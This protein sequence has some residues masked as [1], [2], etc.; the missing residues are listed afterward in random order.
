MKKTYCNLAAAFAV[1]FAA[2]S[3]F[4]ADDGDIYEFKPV[5]DVVASGDALGAAETVEFKMRLLSPN[6]AEA[7]ESK[8]IQWQVYY[9]PDPF[10][11]QPG[12]VVN[13][14]AAWAVNPPKIGIVVSGQT[15]GAALG[16][17]SPLGNRRFTEFD[18]TYTT[19]YGDFALPI[20]LAT[21]DKGTAVGDGQAGA[22]NPSTDGQYYFLNSDTWGIGYLP[23]GASETYENIVWLKP[24]RRQ[25]VSV[26]APDGVR[27]GSWDLAYGFDPAAAG[28]AYFVKTL[29]FDSQTATDS[30]G[31]YWRIVNE[32]RTTC[33]PDVPA[34]K[35][36]NVPQDPQN[37][38]VYVWSENDDVVTV[39]FSDS[40][41]ELAAAGVTKETF[42]DRTG[43]SRDFWVKKIKLD[44]VTVEYPFAIRG[45]AGASGTATTLV[46]SAKLGYRFDGAGD[47]LEDFLVADVKCGDPLLPTVT[48]KVNGG[49]SA[50][51]DAV[52]QSGVA[53]RVATL[54]VEVS[55][56]YTG[57]L[58]VDIAPKLAVD[59]IAGGDAFDYFGISEK[60]E[61]LSYLDKVS[62]VT[63]TA[64]D[65]SVAS[66]TYSKTLY[67]YSWGADANTYAVN[68]SVGFYP[69]IADT[70][71]AAFYSGGME[72][73]YLQVKPIKPV[74]VE[75]VA[76]QLI[77]VNASV[78]YP[79]TVKVS[80]TYNDMKSDTGYELFIKRDIGDL[81]FTSLGFFK[82]DA[83][84]VLYSVPTTEDPEPHQPLVTWENTATETAVLYVK[85]PESKE[86]SEERQIKLYVKPARQIAVEA[87]DG[88]DGNQYVEGEDVT[89]SVKLENG[90]ND[91][92][93]TIYAF[94]VPQSEE[95]LN[96]V[97]A[98]WVAK[99]GGYGREIPKS[100]STVNGIFTLVDGTYETAQ[101]ATYDFKIELR[102]K[103]A[104]SDPGGKVVAG[105]ESKTL[106]VYSKNVIPTA[107]FVELNDGIDTVDTDGAQF[108][109]IIAKDVPTKFQMYV[110]EPGTYDKTTDVVGKKFKTRWIV[111]EQ[112][113][114][115]VSTIVEGN[116]DTIPFE[117]TFTKAGIATIEVDFMDKDM[118]DK[119]NRW[120]N[121][122]ENKKFT[123]K[124][125][126]VSNPLITITTYT[127]LNGFEEAECTDFSG[128]ASI[129]V[130]VSMNPL[131]E[132]LRV[133]L[134]IVPPSYSA[135]DN[136][137]M[138]KLQEDANCT[139][140]GVDGDGNDTYEVTL[141]GILAQTI[142]VKTLDGTPLSGKTPGFMIKSKVLNDTIY[143]NGSGKKSSEYYIGVDR[144]LLV[145]NSDPKAEVTDFY[146][147]PGSTNHVAIGT[148][149]PITWNFTD[150]D[151][152]F[153]KG[154]TVT[155]KQTGGGHTETVY[156]SA[157]ASGSWAPTFTASGLQIVTMTI[158]DKDN[159]R[160]RDPELIWYYEV[161]VS[162]KLNIT[163]NGPAD[164]GGGANSVRYSKAKG[165][166]RGHVY[167]GDPASVVEFTSTYNCGISKT[168][169]IWGF[170]Y[171]VASP[172]DNGTLDG[173]KDFGVTPAGART[174]TEPFY[175]Y[176]SY[177]DKGGQPVDSF[178]YAWLQYTVGEGNASSLTDSLLGGTINP[179]TVSDG[180]TTGSRKL[181]ALPTELL[182]D[183]TYADVMIEA[184]FSREYRSSD[185]MGDMN[186]DGIPDSYILDYG[187]GIYDT[188]GRTVTGDDLLNVAD[189][190]DDEDMLPATASATIASPSS[191]NAWSVAT[192]PFSAIYE[193]RGY[194]DGLNIPG[195][196]EMDM[197]DNE[198]RAFKRYIVSIA[199]CGDPDVTAA[200]EAFTSATNTTSDAYTNETAKLKAVFDKRVVNGKPVW[201][202]EN[203]TDPTKADTD[204]DEIDDGYEYYFWYCAHV[205]GATGER[206]GFWAG[207]VSKPT[208]ISSEEVERLFD[209]NVKRDWNTGGQFATDTDGDGL[210]DMVEIT[211]TFTNPIHW[212][213]DG[214]GMPD[215]LEVM[216]GLDPL[217]NDAS[218]NPD[219][220]FMAYTVVSDQLVV[221]VE[222][223]DGKMEI[224]GLDN[225]HSKSKNGETY[226]KYA[227]VP[228][229]DAASYGH[230][231]YVLVLKNDSGKDVPQFAFLTEKDDEAEAA[232]ELAKYADNDQVLVDMPVRKLYST[233]ET[234]P[235]GGDKVNRYWFGASTTLKAGKQ[236]T[237]ILAD[238]AIKTINYWATAAAL[239]AE[240]LE[241]RYA[242]LVDG[243]HDTDDKPNG[244]DPAAVPGLFSIYRLGDAENGAY[245]V[246]MS[247]RLDTDYK[248]KSQVTGTLTYYKGSPTETADLSGADLQIVRIETAAKVARYHAQIFA[249]NG[250]DPRTGWHSCNDGYC[251]ERWCKTHSLNTKYAEE[252]GIAGLAVNTS[253]FTALNEYRLMHY[254]YVNGLASSGT[255]LS[256]AVSQAKSL[257]DIWSVRTTNPQVTKN[258]AGDVTSHGADTDGDGAPDGWE[259]YVLKNPNPTPNGTD[260]TDDEWD[261]VHEDGA[262]SVKGDGD[263]LELPAEFA[264]TDSLLAYIDCPTIGGRY[265][266]TEEGT[267]VGWI[268]LNKFFPTNPYSSDTDGDGLSDAEEMAVGMD[269]ND[270]SGTQYGNSDPRVKP[271]SFIYG[272]NKD[273]NTD[274]NNWGYAN[275]DGSTCI[276]GGGLNPCTVD[277]DGDRLP[278]G[279]EY[280]FAGIY[281]A[282]AVN[283][284][285]AKEDGGYIDFGMDGTD[286]Y[287]ARTYKRGSLYPEDV[288]PRTG[289]LRN[290]DFDIDGLQNYQEYLTQTLRHFRYDV[291][292]IGTTKESGASAPLIE[293]VMN[294][295]PLY[296][297][298][299]EGPIDYVFGPSAT[300]DAKPAND[301]TRRGFF[302]AP[303]HDWDFAALRVG[304]ARF[305]R[306][307]LTPG[308]TWGISKKPDIWKPNGYV[309]AH[310]Y[311]TTDPRMRDS[312]LD[313]MDDFYELFHGLNPLLGQRSAIGGA[314][315]DLVALAY[316]GLM[317][318]PDVEGVL[319]LDCFNNWFSMPAASSL[320]PFMSLPMDFAKYPWL[321]GMP[322]AD[323]D[324]DGLRNDQEMIQVN[325]ANPQPSNTDPTP[326][327]MTDP[328]FP[329]SFTAQYY[330]QGMLA[331]MWPLS[332]NAS[333]GA[334][335]IE[336]NGYMF[337]F[338]M[339]EGY[340]TDNDGVPDGQEI[341]KTARSA[342]DPQLFTDPMVRQAL[343]FPG[344]V[345]DVS[346]LAI[347]FEPA[348]PANT[349][350]RRTTSA[351]DIFR[352]F[353]V[354]CWI[355]P[356]SAS[357]GVG[358]KCTVLER[359]CAYPQSNYQTSAEEAGDDELHYVRATFRI[360]IE[361]GYLYGL[362][363]NSD[364]QESEAYLGVSSA[365]VVSDVALAADTW[366]HVA[367]TYD[368]AE[369]AIIVK[370]RDEAD[371]KGRRKALETSIIPANGV[372]EILQQPNKAFPYYAYEAY[373]T[374]FLLGASADEVG[375]NIHSVDPKATA[376]NYSRHYVGYIGE[377][378][379]WD[380]VRTID[381]IAAAHDRKLSYDEIVQI[382]NDVY[383]SWYQGGTRSSTGGTE[384]LPAELVQQYTFDGL[385]GA[386]EPDYVA[387]VPSAFDYNVKGPA[388][389][390]LSAAN[391]IDVEVA[392]G[393]LSGLD[394]SLRPSVYND[395]AYVPWIK[396]M[397]A[398]L[399]MMDGSVAD[400]I[401]W[402]EN[403][404]GDHPPVEAEV[405][406]YVFPNTANP[407]AFAINTRDLTSRHM[408]YTVLNGGTQDEDAVSTN[409]T[410]SSSIYSSL[411]D[412]YRFDLRCRMSGT[413]DLVPLGGVYAKRCVDYWDGQGAMDADLV[414]S[415]GMGAADAKGNGLPDW[416]EEYCRDNYFSGMGYDPGMAMTLDT[417]VNYGGIEIKASEAYLRDLAKGMLPTASKDDDFKD[418]TD[419]DYDGMPDWWEKMYGIDT[420]SVEDSKADNDNDGLNNLTE[421]ILSE[422]FVLND[423]DGNRKV[424]SPIDVRSGGTI[425]TDYFFRVGDLY[426]GEIFADH[427]W[428]EDWWE[429]GYNADYVSMLEYDAASDKD[430]DGWSAWAESRYSQQVSPIVANNLFHYNVTDG[431]VPDYPIPTLQLKIRYNGSRESTVRNSSIGVKVGRSLDPSKSFDAEYYVRG[432]GHGSGSVA[433]TTAGSTASSN[434]YT[435]VIGKWSDRHVYGTL[436]PGFINSSS[437]ELQS[438]YDPSAVIYSWVVRVA[439]AQISSSGIGL[440]GEVRELYQ[441]GTKAEYNQAMR[442]YGSDNVTL[443]SMSDGYGK[444]N[445]LEIRTDL[446]SEMATLRF[447][448]G[449]EVGTVNLK[450]GE[451]DLDLGV[452]K[453]GIVQNATNENQLAAL[454][455]QT[456]RFVYSANEST[457][458]PRDLYLGEANNGYIHEGKNSVMVW[459]DLDDDGEF[460]VGEPFGFAC[461]VDIGW[462]RRSIEV[463]IFDRS[464]VTPRVN[465]LASTMNAAVS[466]LTTTPSDR[467]ETI[468]D[469][470]ETISNR[471]VAV[472]DSPQARRMAMEQMEWINVNKYAP[473]E[474]SVG[475][476]ELTRVR[477]V[478][479]L[480]DGTPV[481][482]IGI[483]AEVVFDKMVNLA[484]HPTLTEADLLA[485]G[486]FDID[487]NW[488]AAEL[489]SDEVRLS[490]IESASVAYL[491]VI[492]D[493]PVMWRGSTDS[494][495]VLQV[496]NQVI[497][498]RF[499]VSQ[500]RAA[501]YSPGSAQSVVYDGRPTFSWT[502]PGSS[503]ELSYTAF[504]IQILPESGNGV[505][506]DSG[507]QPMPSRDANGR[508]VWK[509]PAYVGN[510][511]ESSVNYRWRVTGLN[512][513]FRTPLWSE[514]GV[515][516]MEPNTIGADCGRIDVCVKYFGPTAE[517]LNNGRVVVEAFESPDF[518]G[519]PAAR[520]V[521]ADK[522]AVAAVETAHAK[523]VTLLGLRKGTYYVRAYIDS[524]AY[525]ASNVRDSW[526]SW[527]YL[528]D[529]SGAKSDIF[530]P[531]ALEIDDAMGKGDLAVVYIE[532][533][534]TNGNRLPDAWE[535]AIN[536]GRLSNGTS[537]IDKTLDCG[538][539]VKDS[540]ADSISAKQDVSDTNYVGMVAHFLGTLRSRG[541]A[542]LALGVAPSAINVNA[543]GQIVVENEVKSVAIESISFE[544]GK[545]SIAVV[546]NVG[547]AVDAVASDLYDITTEPTKKVVC[548]V[549]RRNS[550]AAEDDWSLVTA[551]EVVVGVG[552]TEIAVPDASEASGFFKVVVRK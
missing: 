179:E 174:T 116:P 186:Q 304:G 299:M 369:F 470:Y 504:Q 150:V 390:S 385:H 388:E 348:H 144:S 301:A 392:V 210:P 306:F 55:D 216:R 22:F 158:T 29:G 382:R 237:S 516:R 133:Q 23:D 353:T 45:V 122:V 307:V 101:G 535:M 79:L 314:G 123:F 467:G 524:N 323:P 246:K 77:S 499:D 161:E 9:K 411:L 13:Y 85:S 309:A 222:K 58:V 347:S 42:K 204:G 178:L 201:T 81:S 479:W 378:R 311:A 345:G 62:K 508:Y 502:I 520:A 360:G 542:A 528:T 427:D 212:D 203:P 401:Y 177:F 278:D 96:A 140:T 317:F 478:R 189:Y 86:K 163:P 305:A 482:K 358:S 113:K 134:T 175:T 257:T 64:A 149:D 138:F 251:G 244:L 459:A 245:S 522:A 200:I 155:I 14:A 342:S 262:W 33:K 120:G 418:V 487:W 147:M 72:E 84:G 98:T 126:I 477:V 136:P 473:A 518:T 420:G 214:D 130:N 402:G 384:V 207:D 94:L 142:Y 48:V 331:A 383:D 37:L 221:E 532:D 233:S 457:G 452:F 529:R 461:D 298:T 102:T 148:A 379:V 118:A 375:M 19:R 447:D 497:E 288:D 100:G 463:E 359:V 302:G 297:M 209:P 408:R 527:G 169:D 90:N 164:G 217:K 202:P 490:D 92:G 441:R 160:V 279:W 243:V 329:Y 271:T 398:H 465:L 501:V 405:S 232:A 545:L 56:P 415:D 354:E 54:T 284:A 108:S 1:A 335:D 135:A 511:L 536:G 259:L 66:T 83:E 78:A 206:Y 256:D 449:M 544:G 248:A 265:S 193:I 50:T 31:T 538:L 439:R 53:T 320:V 255:D 462:R 370:A 419:F 543:S 468:D 242:A 485:D 57:D 493:G 95:A 534:D 91:T 139:Y 17:P 159:G 277:T 225:V 172:V 267:L 49:A 183:G 205:M 416:W 423:A 303:P 20:K 44:G 503:E 458:L 24:Y 451:Y 474:T 340:D 350:T 282:S 460:T 391:G 107:E 363:D 394:A 346:S 403:L 341:T 40:A 80:D 241:P 10:L 109:T 137:G 36:D 366:Y 11:T 70:A 270:Y 261:L 498:R 180:V 326:M 93:D 32:K 168:W 409:T 5:T 475:D 521:V 376:A 230:I 228:W 198:R 364:A 327:W 373:D 453:N 285:T 226:Y 440:V 396:N 276:R 514:V 481:Y 6:F 264:G 533:A 296:Q 154:I 238:G 552:E 410:T 496:A 328:T 223:D 525:G 71:A 157:D 325:T 454:E 247:C 197:S 21:D 374:A 181:I 211:G 486:A 330:Q 106:T 67:V 438:A 199:D 184:I 443:L 28:G 170:G 82:P 431:L 407:Y 8:R 220:D 219:G 166:G 310:S 191:S 456:Y 491:V 404:A 119:N 151:P 352:Q 483:P 531:L 484:E 386:T 18:C 399:P 444:L 406:K 111:K 290:F 156:N 7:L 103:K 466:Y 273:R 513:K 400:S 387:T 429:E 436:T 141:D 316:S 355:R 131:D 425:D 146:P 167:A 74:I 414:T 27:N 546:G 389:E 315:A 38:Y 371:R 551:K 99:D 372:T 3:A 336:G 492:G 430:G 539:A 510:E 448:N 280:Q 365:K 368:G 494:E 435:H 60:A 413:S 25:T 260:A 195:V 506:W 357:I 476:G 312:D 182:D 188:V 295:T 208:V 52:P 361:D 16:L 540:L 293:G 517:V 442:A 362:I 268:W 12:A 192:I 252:A 213:S 112:G 128:E 537:D 412:L 46:M 263:G 63:F 165:I 239:V 332:S 249:E 75:P 287:D 495:T 132:P 313:G 115:P 69:S 281:R 547:A 258:D 215:G 41:A 322:L 294:G 445:G 472:L 464:P 437:I 343:Y 549:Y 240:E 43:V 318:G 292:R 446:T 286:P 59:G 339:N 97:Q 426:I 275:D 480:V 125:E 523:Q 308:T 224:W 231:A 274:D 236:F 39:K 129:D 68:K 89:V 337:S 110:N 272:V 334:A 76:D 469:Y 356:E 417:L 433:G 319:P 500:A 515:F 171:K 422:R 432:S 30:S 127:S 117:Y 550:L 380:G 283:A 266:V 35:I 450:T 519:D 507:V 344:K 253:G 73:A 51:V 234:P 152:D 15:R 526:E 333:S 489:Q 455:D 88:K 190:N 254:R 367:I 61:S 105:F 471:Y 393:W 541:M 65:F 173:G 34:I 397:V 114:T 300:S 324:G 351:A 289:T 153:A 4:A 194:H 269:R 229:A 250:F 321:V 87:M 395:H 548:E 338:E 47:L 143:P 512:A 509:A 104:Y 428:I 124:I 488:L 26:M 187:F 424:F 162:K 291:T 121:G 218:A 421:Y 381:Q 235:E 505:V 227:M 2:S 185:N 530:A 377:V 196:T 349:T 145:K 434:L 176:A